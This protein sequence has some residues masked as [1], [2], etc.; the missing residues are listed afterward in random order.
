MITVE[1]LWAVYLASLVVL[2]LI[3]VVL[4][5]VTMMRVGIGLF[6]AV[7][8]ASVITYLVAITNIDVNSLEQ[9]AKNS[10]QTLY[11]VIIIVIIIAFI[12]MFYLEW[13]ARKNAAKTSPKVNGE[14]EVL[15]IQEDA[16][17]KKD[18]GLSGRTK[19]MLSQL[20][21]EDAMEEK[22]VEAEFKNPSIVECDESGCHLGR[23][24]RSALSQTM[25]SYS[26]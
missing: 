15:V 24:A 26:S 20:Y 18:N 1:Q 2:G 12:L 10:L 6:I 25:F 14:E 3:A 13:S 16:K 9:G 21:Q 17:V 4:S 7:L 23:S 5:R 19:S 22:S 11:W 8:L